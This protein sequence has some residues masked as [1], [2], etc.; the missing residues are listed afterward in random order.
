MRAQVA[1]AVAQRDK[2]ARAALKA[3]KAAM[4]GR[5]ELIDALQESCLSWKDV[6]VPN[7]S[8]LVDV[9]W[10]VGL[11]SA[12]VV[13]RNRE[14][15]ARSPP[16][17]D[18]GEGGRADEGR[19]E[20]PPP[21][22]D[23]APGPGCY[24]YYCASLK[25]P[26]KVIHRFVECP[27][28]RRANV[29]EYEPRTLAEVSEAME[30]KSSSCHSLLEELKELADHDGV[31]LKRELFE[32]A[33][34]IKVI[35]AQDA[36]L[37]RPGAPPAPPPS[38]RQQA[39]VLFQRRQQHTAEHVIKLMAKGSR[40][41]SV[42]ESTIHGSWGELKATAL[43]TPQE[44]VRA[45]PI[46]PE[47]LVSVARTLEL[48][49]SPSGPDHH[50]IDLVIELARAP[51]PMHWELADGADGAPPAGLALGLGEQRYVNALTGEECVG[52]PS[53]RTVSKV[54]A[55]LK[56]RSVRTGTCKPR[57][58]DVWVQFADATDWT[59]YFYNFVTGERCAGFPRLAP[60]SLTPCVLPP[61]R[62]EPSAQILAAAGYDEW[63]ERTEHD[64]KAELFPVGRQRARAERLAHRPCR[65][66]VLIQQG[67]ALGVDASKNPELMWLTDC[68]LTP[69]MPI[70][71][72]T[73]SQLGSEIASESHYH[74]SAVCGLLQWEH[75]EVSYL[76]GVAARLVEARVEATRRA[77]LGQESGSP[78]SKPASPGGGGGGVWS[79]MG[80]D[81]GRFGQVEEGPQGDTSHAG[82]YT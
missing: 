81:K 29:A 62:L 18:E 10:N 68:A 21:E 1:A 20:P 47:T 3:E 35:G 36:I 38:A 69:T 24:C 49:I 50:L 79:P 75:P 31:Q 73:C 61:R 78:K 66:E 15:E 41:E 27:K 46:A 80:Y 19:G 7:S 44:A 71:W 8:E 72:L 60:N 63:A 37:P 52:H 51:I 5:L 82:T 43:M 32:L 22:E 39:W 4:A 54:A 14:R 58:G 28:R 42:G 65:L 77:L 59:P 45:A 25:P 11:E 2:E 26:V 33:G 16:D 9:R 34:A 12:R 53:A 70:G 74:W 57:P 30:Q 48:D 40:Y 67:Y 56:V 6:Y 55:G 76:C 13:A 23:L 17:E 64:A